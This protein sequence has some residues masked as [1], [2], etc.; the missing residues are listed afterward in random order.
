MGVYVLSNVVREGLSNENL[1]FKRL[2]E[3]RT[4]ATHAQSDLSVRALVLDLN[5]ER[6][7][8]NNMGSWP[9]GIEHRAVKGSHGP[10]PIVEQRLVKSLR[11]FLKPTIALI[12]PSL[13]DFGIDIAAACDIRIARED[14]TIT[15]TRV[16]TGRTAASG[17][18]YLLPRLVGLSQAMR[19]S[20]LGETLTANEAL[21]IHFLHQ[22]I[23]TEN[24][25]QETAEFVERVAKMPTRAWEL[26][27]M[28]VLPQLDQD[29]DT[30]MIHSLG[31]RQTHVIKD[32]LE[33]IKAW[34]ERREPEFKGE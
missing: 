7:D 30:A 11:D 22:V 34:R 5:I 33:G 13:C 10:G 8:P 3:L 9:M 31:L 27:K 17:I 25:E 15:D 32:R 2:D 14:S 28:Q 12:G 19:I 26:H 16:A 6:V 21:R 18:A 29:F 23:G 4:L 20:L 24:F 1:S